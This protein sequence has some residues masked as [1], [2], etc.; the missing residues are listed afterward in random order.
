MGLRLWCT[1]DSEHGD[2]QIWQRHPTWSD[3]ETNTIS[4]YLLA[5]ELEGGFQKEFIEA[6]FPR[7]MEKGECRYV[8]VDRFVLHDDY[9]GQHAKHIAA[10]REIIPSID[11]CPSEASAILLV[12]DGPLDVVKLDSGEH[13]NFKGTIG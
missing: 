7:N 9:H 6:L 2:R 10:I 1:R 13:W 3:L 12:S 8:E 5:D 11:D 4:G